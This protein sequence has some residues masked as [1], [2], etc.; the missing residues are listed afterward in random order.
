[1]GE[2]I[3]FR[4]RMPREY[5]KDAMCR[6]Y[7]RFK[8]RHH[9]LQTEIERVRQSGYSECEM[10]SA[11]S[12]AQRSFSKPQLSLSE[13]RELGIPIDGDVVTTI[14]SRRDSK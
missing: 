6:A 7:G 2:V 14:G 3:K 9:R 13:C 11:I 12:K 5:R 1:M 8:Q 10:Q 4:D